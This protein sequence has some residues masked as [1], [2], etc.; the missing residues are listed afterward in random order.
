LEARIIQS[1]TPL[2]SGIAGAPDLN[3]R[4]IVIGIGDGGKLAGHADMGDRV[5]HST[6]YYNSGW[7]NHPDMVAG[8][9][10]GAGNVFS[11]NRGVAAEAELIIES[12][13]SITYRA[14][15]YLEQYGMT[16]T[17]NSYGPS[18]HCSTA[19]QYFGSSASTDQQLF[20]NPRLL[21]VFAVGNSG[22]ST[23]TDAPEGDST[24][25]GGPQTA[26]NT[27]SVGNINAHRR[28]Y[29]TSSAGPTKDGRLKPEIS[30]VGTNVNTTLRNGSY[31]TGTGTSFAAPNVA[32]T[33]ALLSEAFQR[34]HPGDP[35][36]GA[37]LKAV[38]CNTA[39]DA[40]QKGPDYEYGFGILNGYNALQVIENNQFD[41]GTVFK[42]EDN[43]KTI[44]IGEKVS[45][46]KVMLYWNDMAGSTSNTQPVL[47]DDLDLILVSAQGEEIYP[48][49]LD[50]ADPSK[51]AVPGTDQL[52]NI[53][54]V[55][56]Q[57]PSTGEYQII[58]RGSRLNLGSSNYVITWFTT[59]TEVVLTCPYGGG[60]IITGQWT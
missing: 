40:G 46:L 15:T 5:L 27:L 31:G 42:D 41:S 3:G 39:D 22:T 11:A 47:V 34:N 25:P 17:N 60:W 13:S 37:L 30:A 44:E 53:E 14:P 52:N 32:S 48:L 28:R 50:P 45:E 57:D 9:I 23:C 12:S 26:K 59:K 55:V 1:V 20:D 54:Q 19:N 58:V 38:A 18:F 36:T 33:L 43:S 21:H 4:G 10:A 8:I 2:N 35:P 24:I 49:V 56:L 16:I 51:P 6:D 7:G 29:R